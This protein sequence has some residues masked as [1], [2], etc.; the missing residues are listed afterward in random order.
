M[1]GKGVSEQQST[2]RQKLGSRCFGNRVKEFVLVGGSFEDC[3][4]AIA[5]GD[6]AAKVDSR[7]HAISE[8]AVLALG[9]YLLAHRNRRPDPVFLVF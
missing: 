7:F 6:D 4:P 2:V 8:N 5:A 1:A 3:P 9:P